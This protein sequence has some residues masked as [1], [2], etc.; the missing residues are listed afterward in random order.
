MV[1][2]PYLFL[3]GIDMVFLN[4]N[5]KLEEEK[6]KKPYLCQPGI[7]MVFWKFCYKPTPTGVLCI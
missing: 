2:K 6:L 4:S 5:T 1:Q 3:P 7:D